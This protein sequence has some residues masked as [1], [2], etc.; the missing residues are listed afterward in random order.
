MLPGMF[1]TWKMLVTAAAT[2]DNSTPHPA[3]TSSALSQV[4]GGAAPFFEIVESSPAAIWVLR[5]DLTAVYANQACL[6]YGGID[7]ASCLDMGWSV[8]LHP[9]DRDGCF[10]VLR[11][12][13]R[14]QHPL[15]HEC[16]A[17]RA[18]DSCGWV[19]IHAVP[20]WAPATNEVAAL[21]V[22]GT[23]ITRHRHLLAEQ[24]VTAERLRLAVDGSSD[25]VWDWPD[26][27]RPAMWWSSRCYAICGYE[28]GDVEPNLE[29]FIAL[30]HPQDAPGVKHL[31][32]YAITTTTPYDSEFRIRRKDGSY[33]WCRGR[34]ETSRINAVVRMAGSLQDIHAAK[35]AAAEIS[36]L[37]ERYRRAEAGS[38]NGLWEWDLDADRMWYSENFNALL[39][40]ANHEDPTATQR[41]LAT[42]LH[43]E[44]KARVEAAITANL[45]DKIPLDVEFRMIR[46]DGELRWFRSRAM[47]QRI[48]NGRV[49]RLS[50][51]LYDVHDLKLAQLALHDE[52][53]EL[54]TTLSSLG[55]PVVTT[56]ATGRIEFVNQAAE[57]LLGIAPNAVLHRLFDAVFELRSHGLHEVMASPVSLCLSASCDYTGGEGLLRQMSQTELAVE[58]TARKIRSANG[59]TYGVVLLIRDVT[60]KRQQAELIL[61]RATHDALT[62]LVNRYEFER[63]LARVIAQPLQEGDAH[64][65]L[66]LDLDRFKAVNDTC[67]HAGGDELLRQIAVL[68]KTE[69]RRRDT[70]A[71]FG[72]DEFAILME[73]CNL[74]QAERVAQAIRERLANFR[75]PWHTGHF[76]IGVSVGLL[77]IGTRADSLGAVL[78]DADAACYM[79]KELG[80]NR[81]HVFDSNETLKVG[82]NFQ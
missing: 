68:L 78:R 56:D 11:E 81:V 37:Q 21:I 50:G 77:M 39:G 59:R 55:E 36:A 40:R 22:T 45:R 75:F 7:A 13:V 5:P 4:F 35:E 80:R 74:Q 20:W 16:R 61:H 42:L 72:G 44:D 58:F 6:R 8:I 71:R 12:C 46:H 34:A 29:N 69:I 62:G 10:G 52:Q 60:E 64:A 19:R 54:Q 47:S 27:N 31:L 15:T 51:S 38:T 26:V 48:E 63:R 1:T 28:P 2:L 33:R 18:N 65:M 30:V 9:D 25:G 79:A 67:G 32:E 70:V 24:S 3:P 53:D 14:E 57:N 17:Q 49:I 43:V 23:D 66:F 41:R 76:S 82:Q 73:Y